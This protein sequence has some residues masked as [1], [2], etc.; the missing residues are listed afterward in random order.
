MA[1]DS[2]GVVDAIEATLN[3][4]PDTD[5]GLGPD[6]KGPDPAVWPVEDRSEDA[7][8]EYDPG[9]GQVKG[10]DPAEWSEEARAERGADLPNDDG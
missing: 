4:D 6:A 9:E 5:S 3:P 8:D 10:P 7:A 2:G 1:T